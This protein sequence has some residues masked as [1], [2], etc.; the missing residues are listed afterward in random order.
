MCTTT[1]NVQHFGYSGM[2]G[3]RH[4]FTEEGDAR[5]KAARLIA[6]RRAAGYKVIVLDR[7]SRWEVLEPADAVLVPDE[8]GTINLWSEVRE[9]G[10]ARASG[11]ERCENDPPDDDNGR[12]AMCGERLAGP[13]DTWGRYCSDECHEADAEQDRAEPTHEE[14]RDNESA[15][16]FKAP[17]SRGRYVLVPDTMSHR[18]LVGRYEALLAEDV[19]LW[20]DAGGAVAR[21]L[22][23]AERAELEAAL[24][25]ALADPTVG[26]VAAMRLLYRGIAS[27][28]AAEIR[29]TFFAP[30]EPPLEKETRDTAT[31]EQRVTALEE[32]VARLRESVT[33]LL[34]REEV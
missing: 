3:V 18:W 25:R 11:G 1:W 19:R 21:M 28:T 33:G 12:C 23:M 4:T 22:P 26:V 32:E 2:S 15:T 34:A 5:A 16:L 30:T 20:V 27:L 24:R 7:Q 9:C 14:V 29:D 13:P 31:V 6:A 8:C 10:P 17:L